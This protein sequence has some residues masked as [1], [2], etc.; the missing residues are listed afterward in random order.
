[1]N[2]KTSIFL[3]LL[4]IYLFCSFESISATENGFNKKIPI[5][6]NEK[7]SEHLPKEHLNEKKLKSTTYEPKKNMKRL[8]KHIIEDYELMKNLMDSL[9][10]DFNSS[11]FYN[12]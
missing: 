6:P 2:K 7:H 3:V 10:I 8:Q 4:C 1:M 9:K 11:F 5:E 12:L